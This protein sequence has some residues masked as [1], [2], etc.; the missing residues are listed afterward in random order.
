MTDSEFLEAIQRAVREETGDPTARIGPETSAVDVPGWDSLA[1]G[2][3]MLTLEVELGIRIEIDKT[4]SAAKVS[5]L[6][7]ILRASP[8]SANS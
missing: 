2:R 8:R 4:Y 1:H 7:P 5:E 3:I 6:I